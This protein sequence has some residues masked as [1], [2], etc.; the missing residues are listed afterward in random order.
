MDGIKSCVNLDAWNLMNHVPPGGCLHNSKKSPCFTGKSTISITM[1]SIHIFLDAFPTLKIKNSPSLDSLDISAPQDRKSVNERSWRTRLCCDQRFLEGFNAKQHLRTHELLNW[2]K[3]KSAR[4]PG[5]SSDII[6]IIKY[7]G[8]ER[9]SR[10]FS[11]Q[12]SPG[13]SRKHACFV[14]SQDM[15]RSAFAGLTNGT[16]PPVANR[17]SSNI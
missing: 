11:L 4:R 7:E 12:P 9:F 2:F 15:L 6:D 14:D 3:R 8:Y 17:W 16:G 10:R 1:C 13:M 5:A